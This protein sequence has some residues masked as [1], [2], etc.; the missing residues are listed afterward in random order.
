M[1]VQKKKWMQY[2]YFN[3]EPQADWKTTHLFS[4]A[5]QKIPGMVRAPFP[6]MIVDVRN[7]NFISAWSSSTR[8][9]INKAVREELVADRGMNLLPDILKLFSY[10]AER[11]KLRGYKVSDFDQFECMECSAIVQDGVILCGHVWLVD[12]KEKRA[13]LYVNAVNHDNENDDASLTGRAHYFL[14]WQ[15]GLFLR[16]Q[17]IDILDLMG[18]ARMTQDES[19]KGVYTWKAGTHGQEEILHHYYPI[20]FYGFRRFRKLLTG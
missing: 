7:E 9:K 5:D 14:L 2:T 8:T 4:F 12:K 11:K 16:Q 19:L 1:I 6:T 3:R 17:G 20:W 18:Y 15:D 10:T 13:L